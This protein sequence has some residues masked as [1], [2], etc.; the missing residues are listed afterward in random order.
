MV[1]TSYRDSM[2]NRKE[3]LILLSQKFETFEK[4]TN[5]KKVMYVP[6]AVFWVPI[7]AVQSEYGFWSLTLLLGWSEHWSVACSHPGEMN[8][9]KKWIQFKQQIK[10][11]VYLSYAL[12]SFWFFVYNTFRA[13]VWLLMPVMRGWN[14]SMSCFSASSV[15]ASKTRSWLQ[16]N[17]K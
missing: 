5:L 15:M 2:R 10:K 3:T 4:S 14:L 8:L 12:N 9:A 13:M 1:F 17:K 6:P 11:Q 7:F 16:N